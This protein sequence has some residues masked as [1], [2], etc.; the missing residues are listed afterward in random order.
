MNIMGKK[1][2][3]VLVAGVVVLLV[4]LFGRMRDG[5]TDP[6]LAENQ[7]TQSDIV[8]ETSST[9]PA[10]L[11]GVPLEGRLALT[12]EDPLESITDVG[13]LDSYREEIEQRSRENRN[14]AASDVESGI[15][16]IKKFREELGPEVVAQKAA[17]FQERMTDLAEELNGSLS[18]VPSAPSSLIKK[19]GDAESDE[20]RKNLVRQFLENNQT[21]GPEEQDAMLKRLDQLMEKDLE[22]PGGNP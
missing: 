16:A 22:K 6:S 1:A 19:I 17:E 14:V 8:R 2:L 3:V 11:P 10:A 4:V 9:H 7:E 12:A 5:D 20:E 15:S 18:A 13:R 21:L